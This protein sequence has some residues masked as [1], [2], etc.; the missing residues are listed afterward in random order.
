MIGMTLANRYKLIEKVGVGGMALVYKAEDL[1]LKRFVAVKILKEQFVEDD[2]FSRKFEMEAQSAA[3]LSHPNIVNVYDVGSENNGEGK[4][5]FIVMEYINGRTLKDLIVEK[6]FLSNEDTVIYA[7]QIAQALEAAHKKGIIHRDIKPQNIMITDEDVVKVTDFGIARIS[8]SATITY[9]QS[10]L[11]TVHYISP[12]QA[13]G[14]F[15]DKRSDIYS[16]GIVMYEMLTGKVPFDAENSVGIALKHIQD[17]VIEPSALNPGVSE[18]LNNIIM[19]CLEKQPEDRYPSSNALIRDLM[20]KNVSVSQDTQVTAKAFNKKAIAGR[21]VVNDVAVYST[22][23]DNTEKHKAQKKFGLKSTVLPIALSLLLLAGLFFLGSFLKDNF[24]VR[25]TVVPD[26]VGKSEAEAL[27]LLTNSKLKYNIIRKNDNNISAGYVISQRPEKGGDVKEGTHIELI[28][29]KG[30][31]EITMPSLIDM[32]I[33]E[34]QNTLSALGLTISSEKHEVSSKEKEGKIISQSPAENTIVTNK[35]NIVVT[36]AKAEEVQLSKMPALLGS[37]QAAAVESILKNELVLGEVEKRYSDKYGE[38]TVMWQSYDEG[39][40]LKPGT[41]IDLI[42]SKGIKKEDQ[43]DEGKTEPVIDNTNEQDNNEKKIFR[44]TI[45]PPKRDEGVT[46]FNVRITRV[47]ETN[48]V[49][50]YNKN[51]DITKGEF[52]VDVKDYVN[53]KFKIYFDGEFVQT[54]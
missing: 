45:L 16:L 47:D 29:S 28:I 53:S 26:I 22:S 54:N 35:S 49:E 31:K 12:E 6:T 13:K 44:F 27:N 52:T 51:H 38:D 18:K 11:G 2:E 3:A 46:E 48:E 17:R 41:K 14:K 24:F 9:T 10:I 33:N 7:V 23:P 39:V 32:D 15:I 30:L 20:A 4:I 42:I 19:K 25:T 34:A 1:L 5:H 36:I 40:E 50:V 21:D 37:T 43:T 8:T